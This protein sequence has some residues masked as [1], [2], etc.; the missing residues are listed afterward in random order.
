[1]RRKDGQHLA[2]EYD[3][4]FYETAP[5]RVGTTGVVDF[6]S[7]FRTLKQAR[8][9]SDHLPVFMEVGWK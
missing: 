3:N 6:T 4:I 2:N 9:I 1:M 5:L 8:E 7:E